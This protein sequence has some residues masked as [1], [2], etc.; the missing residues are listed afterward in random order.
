MARAMLC[1]GPM[2]RRGFTLVELMIVV[3]IVG[4]LAALAIYGFR[5][6]QQSAGTGEATAL[7]QTFKGA[8]EAYRAEFLTYG[9]CTDG[10]GAAPFSANGVGLSATDLY[11]RELGNIKETKIQWGD[12]GTNMGQCFRA[13]GFRTSGAV[14]FSYGAVA[15]PPD[16]SGQTPS[17]PGSWTRSPAVGPPSEPWYILVAYGD[18]DADSTYARLSTTSQTS[19][20]QMED[21]TE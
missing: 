9:G 19:E 2:R 13:M 1:V 5:R 6:Y 20:V 8:E 4:I 17:V 12:V 3:S 16:A 14:R 11:P 18:R 7:L 15:G 21:E 10:T